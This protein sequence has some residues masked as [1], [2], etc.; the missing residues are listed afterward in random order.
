MIGVQYFHVYLLYHALDL[1][2]LF[3]SHCKFVSLNNSSIIPSL[4]IHW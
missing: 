2:D 1:Y 4:P 3:T